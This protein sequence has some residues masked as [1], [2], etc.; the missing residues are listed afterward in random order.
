MIFGEMNGKLASGSFFRKWISLV[1][2]ENDEIIEMIVPNSCSK[3]AIEK[4]INKII[5]GRNVSF[6]S[7]K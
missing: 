2:G 1:E 4:K 5:K 6:I 7:F 3:I